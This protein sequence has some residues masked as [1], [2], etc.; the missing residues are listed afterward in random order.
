MLLFWHL[1]V[2]RGKFVDKFA[3]KQGYFDDWGESRKSLE[4]QDQKFIDVYN[5]YA[6]N[7]LGGKDAMIPVPKRSSRKK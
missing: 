7:C 2:L 5:L 1:E 4:S 6:I 3:S